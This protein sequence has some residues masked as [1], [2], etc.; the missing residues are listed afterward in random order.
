MAS[1]TS[2]AIAQEKRD[3]EDKAFRADIMAK[4]VELSAQIAEL[5]ATLTDKA[6]AKPTRGK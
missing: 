5:Q 1:A 3:A 2:L 4:L 6:P